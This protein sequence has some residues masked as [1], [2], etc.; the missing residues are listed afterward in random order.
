[1]LVGGLVVLAAVAHARSFG[2]DPARLGVG[3]DSAGA[4]LAAAVCRMAR[5]AG[6]PAPSFQL[7]LCP[8]LD[9]ASEAPSR[10][11]SSEI[12]SRSQ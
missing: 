11:L 10:R 9:V 1:M 7:L 2:I 5:D 4:N 12:P 3:G 8:I 6:A